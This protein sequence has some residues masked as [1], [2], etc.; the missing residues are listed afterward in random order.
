MSKTDSERYDPTD[1][2]ADGFVAPDGAWERPPLGA[3]ANGL[4]DRTALIH[5]LFPAQV[6]FDLH[7]TVAADQANDDTP[8][9]ADLGHPVRVGEYRILRLIGRGGMGAVYEAVQESLGRHVALK[10]LPAEALM[11]PV[12]LERFRREARSAAQLH[13]T[14]I[15][16]VFG[17]GKAD[18][19][20]FYAM[21]FIAGHP[22][23]A[24]IEEVRRLK[25]KSGAR[26]PRSV[27]EV[28]VALMKRGFGTALTVGPSTLADGPSEWT[29]GTAEASDSSSTMSEI[30][31]DGGRHY[32][33][34]VA[35]LGA[36]GADALA[37]AHAQGILHRDIKPANLLL[38]LQGTV[39]VTDFGLAKSNDADNL[40]QQ[41]DIVGTLRY[42][43][44]ERFDGSG[45]HRS[46][47]YALGLTLY[48]M[49]TLKPAFHHENRAKLI[50]QV[51]AASPPRPRAINPAIPRD[52]ETIVLK[53]IQ[54]D[55]ALRYQ[56][57]ADLG[58]DLH[59]YIED[60]PIRARRATLTEQ[61]VRW[62]RRNPA[63]ALLVA[64]VMLATFTGA[65]L[66]SF[67]AV[68][69]ENER[70]KAVDR[71]RE[72]NFARREAETASV[73]ATIA[74]RAA[75]ESAEEAR[76]R[77]TRLYV[78][79]GV[80]YQDDRDIPAALLWFHRAWEQD[81]A[82]PMA[83]AAHRTRIAGALAE[84]PD[85][86]GACFHK[87]KVCD[88]VF[89]A[90]GRR[91]LTRTDGNEAYLWDYEQSRLAAPALMHAGRVRHIGYSPDG[92]SVATASADGTACVWDSATGAKRF[93]LKH[94]GPLTW[95]AFHPDG[96]RIATSAEDKTV[97][98]WSAA[99]GKPL[100]WRLPVDTVI[101]HL[102]FSRDGSRLV[103]AGRDKIV[104]VWDVDPP[105]AISPTLPYRQPTDT[106]RYAF[107]QDSWPKFAQD[108]RGVLSSDGKGL[109]VW[110]GGETDAVRT[111]SFG[112]R[113]W[114]VETYFVPNSD[115]VLVTGNSHVATVVELNHG[116]V[117]HE[118]AHPREANLGAVS[119]DGKWLLTCSS[120]GLVTLWDA[121]TGLRAGPPQR[122]GDFCSAVI[123]SPDS[124]RYLA[125]SQDG[126]VRVWT[127]GPRTPPSQPYQF[128]CGRAN[129]LVTV[130]KD[131]ST[132]RS[133]S[134]D[135]RRWVEWT[136][137]G[138]A[139]YGSG[140]PNVTPQPIPHPGP[141]D[142]ARFSDDGSRLVVDGGGGI[143][144]W[145][146]DTVT[147]AGPIVAAAT[148]TNPL[149]R[150][151]TRISARP[152]VVA[153]IPA[154]PRANTRVTPELLRPVQ[155]SRDGTRIVCLDDEK[156]VSV[157]DLTAGR[158]V[159]GPARHPD[160]GPR[161]FEQPSQAGWV[162]EAA[163]SADGRRLAVAIE[164]TGTLTVW[165]VETGE[166]VHHNRRFR[167]YIRKVQFS[168]DGRRILLSS[169]DGM[170]RMYDADTGIPLGPAASQ[171]SGQLA[172]GVSPDGRRLA[173]YDD[174]VNG[175]RMLDVERGERL[176]TIPYGDRTRPTA[177]WFDAA[178]GSLNAVVGAESLTFS[179]PRFDLPFADSK[180]L[181]QFLTGQ[182]IDA[183]EGIEFVDQS[184]FRKDSDRFRD[185]FRAWKT[186]PVNRL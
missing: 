74:R 36:Q 65:G 78:F 42:M 154:D 67:Y 59:R 136:E 113:P 149:W 160:P 3:H 60:R 46:D 132:L 145:H 25:E 24:V 176:L 1:R 111:I 122:C 33:A 114:V 37:Y 157:W 142:A 48:E 171:P 182:E 109:A 62:C 57:A 168:D 16:P 15:V 130:M 55:P 175:F 134:P 53:A 139:W 141:V 45:D 11:D 21:Q 70:G 165:D 85:L 22:L 6:E 138:K 173:V 128:D 108:G 10:L 131:E 27:S 150:W 185:V 40:T 4:H 77:L 106:E 17:V 124:S 167:G 47:L 117:V 110:A 184:T 164:T 97:R 51:T 146:V 34:T 137:D 87:T 81:H 64:A 99:D 61:T 100:A 86:I 35:R 89:S 119:P 28:A 23:D 50:E 152:P 143:R 174:H 88:A 118:L 30:L 39:W 66:A 170:A 2:C 12:R 75:E 73:R 93:S 123:F 9:V 148:L 147:P 180:A 71:E 69:A 125:A 94:D 26:A 43:A 135:G 104:R 5:N 98:L 153:A 107:N 133:Y 38:D 166:I 156:T 80:R 52:L 102:A 159:F 115:H 14:N 129:L 63:V 96:Q 162:S 183:T 19:Q 18:G 31:S 126:T 186:L 13:H 120:G 58:D 101:D 91:V 82:D 151:N 83:D 72:A 121:A 76:K 179:L 169:S 49:L 178:G 79:S 116:G 155:L 32:W 105:R 68:R 44:P 95:V 163:L 161:I 84:M 172:V 181:F 8:R 92:N 54:R 20:H 140:L 144:A 112:S 7:K 127:T 158:R 177:L 56:S 29:M 41:G 103:T 90:D